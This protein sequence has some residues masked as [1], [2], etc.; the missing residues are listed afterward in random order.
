MLGDTACSVQV[1]FTH[2]P[3]QTTGKGRMG[4][5]RLQGNGRWF[6]RAVP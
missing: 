4:H 2:G 1:V 6:W 5:C 3:L